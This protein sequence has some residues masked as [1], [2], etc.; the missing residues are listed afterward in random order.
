[1]EKAGLH[2]LRAI[3]R[4][5]G[6]GTST[7]SDLIYGR[8]QS[9]ESTMQAVADALRQNVTTVREWAA[10]NRGETSAFILPPEANRLSARERDAVLGVIRAMLDPGE[11]DAGGPRGQLV[12]LTRPPMPDLSR[13]AARRGESEGRRL[14][15]E[16]DDTQGS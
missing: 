10:V 4:K 7:V 15:E 14:R 16:Q 12:D 5:A 1:M 2:S 3:A 11:E 6:I 9:D 8:S 13:V